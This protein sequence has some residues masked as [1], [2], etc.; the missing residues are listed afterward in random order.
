[1]YSYFVV[2]LLK[3]L[4]K[5]SVVNTF[6]KLLN[7]NA[8]DVVN[9]YIIIISDIVI[10]II[11]VLFTTVLLFCILLL[12]SS[13]TGILNIFPI[14]FRIIEKILS[15][16]GT[17]NAIPKIISTNDIIDFVNCVSLFP[18][19]NIDDIIILINPNVILNFDF[20]YFSSC[21]LNITSF[22]GFL[23]VFIIADIDIISC[24]KIVNIIT[25]IIYLGSTNASV[26]AISM[27]SLIKNTSD[28]FHVSW[29]MP[30]LN[31]GLS[32]SLGMICLERWDGMAGSIVQ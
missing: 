6:S 4:I 8:N 16:S 26:F 23:L 30:A 13:N 11:S 5:Q 22:I 18:R 25:K 7:N 9:T 21:L 32:I 24:K 15:I 17:S 2:S 19:Y 10:V 28:I 20:L 27:L 1:M 31:N 3:C 12:A 14:C 29:F